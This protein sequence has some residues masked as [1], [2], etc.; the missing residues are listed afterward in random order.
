MR[1][2][3]AAR[4]DEQEPTSPRVC[5]SR[6]NRDA[7]YVRGAHRCSFIV[8]VGFVFISS[9]NGPKG[10]VQKCAVSIRHVAWNRKINWNHFCPAPPLPHPRRDARMFS[11]QDGFTRRGA[12][13]IHHLTPYLTSSTQSLQDLRGKKEAPY[14]TVTDSARCQSNTARSSDIPRA[15]RVTA[16]SE[17][18]RFIKSYSLIM[19]VRVLSIP[20][21]HWIQSQ[22]VL[23]SSCIVNANIRHVVIVDIFIFFMY[24]V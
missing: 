11:E 7:R 10:S 3:I 24:C 15:A 18:S 17:T 20:L 19:S 16:R 22:H 4:D 23:A 12:I 14:R 1:L 13:M 8:V 9:P 21:R 6:G 2:I 5:H